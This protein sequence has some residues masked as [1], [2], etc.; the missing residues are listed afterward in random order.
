MRSWSIFMNFSQK[1]KCPCIKYTRFTECADLSGKMVDNAGKGCYTLAINLRNESIE[2]RFARVSLPSQE[3]P[4]R[5]GKRV[6][7]RSF[8]N[9]AG[10]R[11][12]GRRRI[13]AGLSQN[14]LWGAINGKLAFILFAFSME[15]LNAK[16]FRFLF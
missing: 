5:Q 15:P 4:F 11:M 6:R 10:L 9:L 12:L 7:R 14:S 16:R 3:Q 13:S 1:N 2:A 8:H